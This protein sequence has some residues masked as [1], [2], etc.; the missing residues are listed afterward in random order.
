MRLCGLPD[1]VLITD[2]PLLTLLT[3]FSWGSSEM[4]DQAFQQQSIARTIAVVCVNSH[5][6][7]MVA[8]SIQIPLL[9]QQPR[10]L[11]LKSKQETRSRRKTLTHPRADPRICRYLKRTGF[12]LSLR[13]HLGGNRARLDRAANT[14]L[15]QNVAMSLFSISF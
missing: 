6:Y 14:I 10:P 8:R 3:K 11:A 7:L 13:R 5:P 2:T 4:E 1:G 9:A 15:D 12:V